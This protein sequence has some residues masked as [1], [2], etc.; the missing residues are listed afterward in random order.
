MVPM[1]SGV[2]P[3]AT[4][5]GSGVVMARMV[6]LSLVGRETAGTGQTSISAEMVRR[7]GCG[8]WEAGSSVDRC[9]VVMAVTLSHLVGSQTSS[10]NKSGIAAVVMVSMVVSKCRVLRET[11]FPAVA[12]SGHR[13]RSHEWHRRV[14]L[15]ALA[16][17]VIATRVCGR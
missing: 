2:V 5:R 10:A 7:V 17:V 6:L 9:I 14:L 16:V 13:C 4:S 8:R 12:I 15:H 3:H 11:W 1:V